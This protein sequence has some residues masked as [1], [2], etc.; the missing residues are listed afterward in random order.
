MSAI[1]GRTRRFLQGV[2]EAGERG[3]IGMQMN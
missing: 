3:E 1:T 2:G